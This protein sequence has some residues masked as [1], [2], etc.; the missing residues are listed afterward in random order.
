MQHGFLKGRSV[1]T[2]LLLYNDFLS[3]AFRE[4]FKVDSIYI[5][6][7]KAFDTVNHRLLLQKIWNIGIR[8]KLH[9]WLQSYLVGRTQRVRS[10][11]SMSYPFATPSGVPQGSNIGPILFILFINDLPGTLKDSAILLYADDAKIYKIVKS[12]SDALLLQ[13]DLDRLHSWAIRNGLQINLLKCNVISFLR[14]VSTFEFEYSIDS[15]MLDKVD[16]IRDLGVIYD[17]S[18][19]FEEQIKVVTKKCS[20]ILG[21]IRNVTFDFRSPHTLAHLYKSLLLPVLSYC[22]PSWFPYT[23]TALSQLVAIEHKFLRLASKKTPH[24]MHFFDHNYDP[25]RQLLRLPKLETFLKKQDCI[26]SYNIAKGLYS[27]KEVNSLF[28]TRNISHNLRN[29]LPLSQSLL[30]R[31]YLIGSSTN[32]LQSRWNNLPRSLRDSPSL[33]AFKS[34]LSKFLAQ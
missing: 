31:N 32:R 12:P 24:P 4:K 1:L 9:S 19:T 15:V 22:S 18:L 13:R 14:G 7:S 8:G 2:N 21:F 20:K 34:N 10:C 16:T 23:Q 5:D 27:S 6:F 17:K 29:P 25:I 26:V 28:T 30:T 3:T 11:G 33:P